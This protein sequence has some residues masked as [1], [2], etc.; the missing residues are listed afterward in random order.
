MPEN[1]LED[2]MATAKGEA[3]VFNFYLVDYNLEYKFAGGQL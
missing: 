3:L 1:S 2:S